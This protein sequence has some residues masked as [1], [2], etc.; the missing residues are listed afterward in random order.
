MIE[1][2]SAGVTTATATGE[3]V[4]LRLLD[5]A[6]RLIG[7]RGI[8][9]VSLRSINAGAGSNVAAAH[10]HFG[11]KVG[12]VRAVLA[13]RMSILA[14]ERFEMLAA[15]EH[16]PAPPARAVVEVFTLPLMRLAATDD[17]AA[18]VR[19]LCALDRGGDRWLQLLDEGFRPQWERL[20][21]VLARATPDVG[22][23]LRQMRLSVAG[24]TLLNMLADS[25]RHAGR[26]APERYR[27]EVVD[28]TTSILIGTT[29][30]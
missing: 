6:E 5:A 24:T 2:A 22:D 20:A 9:A 17:G 4:Q 19:F 1:L 8:D 29:T 18:Y 25:D 16:D 26:L 13:R 27:D 30:P 12:L 7:E 21:P 23:A 11:S 3:P 10:Y 15:L 28:V 14:A